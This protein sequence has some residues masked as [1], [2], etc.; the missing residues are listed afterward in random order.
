MMKQIPNRRMEEPDARFYASSILLALEYLHNN[1]ITFRDLK[2]ENVLVSDQGHICVAD[3]GL[4]VARSAETSS[5]HEALRAQKTVCGTPEYM[6][7]EVIREDGHGKLVDYW[8]LGVMIYEMLCGKTPWAGLSA[9][10]MFFSVLTQAVPF[11]DSMSKEAR[12]LISSLMA[13]DPND[14]LGR[15]GPEEVKKHAFFATTDWDAMYNQRI[16]PPFVPEKH[17]SKHKIERTKSKVAMETFK[18]TFKPY[19]SPQRQSERRSSSDTGVE[20]D[21]CS[22]LASDEGGS[23]AA[24]PRSDGGEAPMMLAGSGV[25]AARVLKT[26]PQKAQPTSGAAA[27]PPTVDLAKS[28]MQH[29]R[30][31]KSTQGLVLVRAA[32]G[33]VVQ[34]DASFDLM[35]GQPISGVDILQFICEAERPAAKEALANAA[36]SEQ[37]L[38]VTMPTLGSAVDVHIITSTDCEGSV[39]WWQTVV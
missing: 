33:V 17:F 18:S 9:T 10:D 24:S 39:L 26:T 16:R 21:S 23:A 20:D 32:T 1:G 25:A 14:R 27:A 35:M 34:S 4:A 22:T 11:P 8:A 30:A 28:L 2:P 29:Q 6:A 7:P 3:F 31:F 12:S 38:R 15:N 19:S 13:K 5:E 36:L 37:H